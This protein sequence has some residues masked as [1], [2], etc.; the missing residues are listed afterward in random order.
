MYLTAE[1]K[2]NVAYSNSEF[3]YVTGICKCVTS[4]MICYLLRISL[5]IRNIK[6]KSEINVLDL[7]RSIF[8][9]KDIV[10]DLMCLCLTNT[11]QNKMSSTN[12]SLHTPLP[13]SIEIPLVLEMKQ[14][15]GKQL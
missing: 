6:K 11:N 10:F 13:N 14:A 4:R 5:H 3:E 15:E 9:R 12:F 1:R 7:I 2:T 8:L